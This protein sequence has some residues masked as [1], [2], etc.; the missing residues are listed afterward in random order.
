MFKKYLSIIEKHPLLIVVCTL[1][2][3]IWVATG[4]KNLTITNDFRVFFSKKNPQLKALENLDAEFTRED[5]IIV[6]LEPDNGEVFSSSFLQLVENI[7][8]FAWTLPYCKRV[9]S[10]TNY[11]YSYAEGDELITEFLVEE[12]SSLSDEDLARIENIAQGEKQLINNIIN[13]NMDVS[14]VVITFSYPKGTK[15]A[16]LESVKAAR[17][18]L[19]V[20]LKD[21][22]GVEARLIGGS[23]LDVTLNEAV[24]ADMRSLV[25]W[26]YMVI[27]LGLILLLR[28][29]LQALITLIVIT[30]SIMGTFGVFGWLGFV[31]SPVAGFVPSM[32]M[33]IAV[34]D[35]VHILVTFTYECRNGMAKKEAMAK[36]MKINFSPVFLTSLTTVIGMLC[37]NFSDSPPYQD[38]GNMLSVGV[39]IAWLLSISLLPCLLLLFP[40]PKT[41]KSTKLFS[42]KKWQESYGNWALK[43]FR[44][45][46]FGLCILIGVSSYFL[47]QNRLAEKWYEYFDTSFSLRKALDRFDEKLSGINSIYYALDGENSDGVYSPEYLRALDKFASWYEEQEGVS[48]VFSF[49]EIVKQLNQKLHGDD[50]SFYKIPDNKKLIAQYVLLYELGLPQGLGLDNLINIDRSQSK[51]TILTNKMDSEEILQLETKAASWYKRNISEIPFQ[52]ATGLSVIFAHMNHRNARSMVYGSATAL[53]IIC[54]V[55]MVFLKSFKIGLISIGPNFVPAILAYGFWGLYR[56]EVSTSAAVV[57]CLCLG[58]I[59]D[60]TVHFLSKYLYFKRSTGKSTQEAIVYAFNTVGVALIITSLVLFAGFMVLSFSHFAPTWE[61]GMLVS[62]TIAMAL[63]GDFLMLPPLLMIFDKSKKVTSKN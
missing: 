5:N 49:A 11:L 52:E 19:E 16:N 55:L 18:M 60:D 35:C 31:L 58:I 4:A 48:H 17:N 44:W 61:A 14:S 56:G 47:M 24:E 38:L 32:L 29:F 12:A 30:V 3:L 54:L 40:A 21:Y 7:T 63:I 33:T 8:E 23:V 43:N 22:H 59:V 25:L 6:F 62:V 13:P 1:V 53:A 42:R 50:K 28:S 9:N 45:I 10:L 20:Q 41:A 26:S 2:I 34:A 46:T 51:L 15:T 37:L 27:G 36:A 39:V 57:M